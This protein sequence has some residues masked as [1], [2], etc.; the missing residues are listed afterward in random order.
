MQPDQNVHKF[1]GF[2]RGKKIFPHGSEQDSKGAQR[3]YP[4]SCCHQS[5][6]PL[7]AEEDV[8][9]VANGQRQGRGVGSAHR[10]G[11]A[12]RAANDLDG[13]RI[14][15]PLQFAAL[16]RVNVR[17]QN[18]ITNLFR[19]ADVATE[20]SRNDIQTSTRREMS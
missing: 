12:S 2:Y 8:G 4:L 11:E 16:Y 19:D 13:A 15:E 1:P 7:V 10:R 9:M 5:G 6:N 17:R 14:Q 18:L 3:S 20:Q